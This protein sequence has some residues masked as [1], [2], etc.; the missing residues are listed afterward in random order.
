MSRF[1]CAL[2]VGLV[3][4]VGCGTRPGGK[5]RLGEVERLPHLEV[6][7]PVFHDG[8]NRPLLP[9]WHRYA[10][11][12]DALEKAELC[13]QVRGTI[14]ELPARLDI[15]RLVKK[16]EELL[17]LEIPDVVAERDTKKA[18]VNQNEKLLAQSVQAV[19]VAKAEVK[20]TEALIQRA[21]ADE[22]FQSEQFVRVA[23]LVKDGTVAP[24]FADEARLKWE[25][26]QAA[27]A[28]AESQAL[29]KQARLGAAEKE[30][31][32]AE[33]RVQVASAELARLEALVDFATIRA[34]FDGVITKRWVNPGVT[35]KDAGMPLLTLMRTDKVRVLIDAPERDVPFLTMDNGDAKGN[36]VEL[37]IPALDELRGGKPITATVTLIAKALDP[38]TR[39]MR[40]EIHLDNK[41]G[42]LRPE[43]TGTA[44]VKLAERA[45]RTVPASALV[46][47]GSK[48]EI[49]V[50]ADAKGSPPR[51][52][53][54][55]I[56]VQ[57]GLD[58]GQRVE[59]RRDRLTGRELTGK[60]MVIIKGAGV[61][62]A[63]DEVIAILRGESP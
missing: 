22:R 42:V 47:S 59:I 28:A 57:I 63:G 43:M 9:L 40:T 44:R 30:K 19:V 5:P 2:V 25:S 29:T 10:A 15:G 60:E 39:T 36:P 23:K 61:I 41:D 13:A 16:G 3:A 18:T 6:E 53:V 20:E 7:Y 24:Q 58:D 52:V 12:V 45:A 38:V 14:K 54:K 26:A 27:L 37:D 33:A 17:T 49:L 34:P 11:T 55:A 35:V 46:R 32:V 1:R 56:D 48:M 50:V 62:R 31:Q 51:G 21:K 4:A 8:K